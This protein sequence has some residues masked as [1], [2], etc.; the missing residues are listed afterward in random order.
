MDNYAS[1]TS[2]DNRNKVQQQIIEE[3]SNNRYIFSINK[4]KIV[5]ALGAIPKKDS[6]KIRLIHDCSRPEGHSINDMCT[7]VPFQYQTI[8]DATDML[9]R[10]YFMCKLDLQQAYRSVK[11][12]RSNYQATG[13]KWTFQNENG[14]Q[15]L[16]YLI[17]TRLPFGSRHA[18]RIFD[19]LGRAVLRIMGSKGFNNIV[20]ML[21]DFLIVEKTHE[22][23]QKTLLQLIRLLRKLGFAINYNKVIGP[24]QHIT[25]LGIDIDSIAMTTEIPQV[26]IIELHDILKKTLAKE[27]LSKKYLQS[28]AGKLNFAAQC[29][30]GGRFYLRRIF[31]QIGRLNKPWHRTRVTQDMR[32]DIRFWVDCLSVL[33]GSFPIVDTRPLAPLFIDACPVAAGAC[34]GREFVYTPWGVYPECTNL[35]INYLEVLSLEPALHQWA[36]LFMNRRII[37]HCDNQAAVAIINKGSCRNPVVMQS[38]RR[39]FWLSVMFNFRMHAVYYSGRDNVHADA[40][41]RLHDPSKLRALNLTALLYPPRCTPP[42]I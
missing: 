25:F 8:S 2:P 28:L 24:S 9:Q 19:I 13:L 29:V 22:E 14:T 26:K 17:D 18:P 36:P 39:M 23:C 31:D 4:P 32:A 42:F 40:I 21:D 12:H 35:P 6:E 5:S 34:F 15:T 33:N 1:A 30:Y 37:V 27:K 7:K 11:I 20:V 38:L 41:S 16:K 3:I 10:G